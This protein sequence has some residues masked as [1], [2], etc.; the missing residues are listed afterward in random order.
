MA[1]GPDRDRRESRSARSATCSCP[2]SRVA[3]RSLATWPGPVTWVLEARAG[4]PRWITGGRS[5]VAVRVT[6]H[7]VA[8]ELCQRRRRGARLDERQ[9]EPAAARIG[10]CCGCAASS[11]ASRLR[12]GRARSAGSRNLPSLGTAARVGL[13]GADYDARVPRRNDARRAAVLTFRHPA[14]NTRESET[15]SGHLLPG[16]RM[17]RRRTLL[18][19][20]PRRSRTCR[21]RN[22][23]GS[24]VRF[25]ARRKAGRPSTSSS[26]RSPARPATSAR[27]P[28][29]RPPSPAEA[30][31][32]AHCRGRRTLREAPR[33]DSRS[34]A[35]PKSAPPSAK[36][37]SYRYSRQRLRRRLTAAQVSRLSQSPEVERVWHDTDQKLEHQQQRDLLRA[38]EPGRRP[39]RRSELRGEDVVVGVI[40]SG[41]A[42]QHPSLLDTEDRTPRTCRSDWAK[43]LVARLVVVLALSPQSAAEARV[44]PAGR[45]HRRLPSR[46]RLRADATATTRSSARASISTAFLSRN[47]LDPA[48]SVAE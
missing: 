21:S 37:Y 36:L 9:R 29:T 40:D 18:H 4:A 14:C 25:A 45:L 27:R 47:E 48:S 32:H 39:A 46:P 8:R 19:R 34:P 35:R 17:A 10:S 20:R 41:V 44:R 2:P 31:A 42:P 5:T 22:R 15:E 16:P 7:P 1:Q 6:A 23:C 11:A 28:T 13:C 30:I 43:I 24:P 26:S 3:A 38:A 33:A 12:P